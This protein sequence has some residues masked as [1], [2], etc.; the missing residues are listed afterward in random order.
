MDSKPPETSAGSAAPVPQPATRPPTPAWVKVFIVLGVL[1][2]VLIIVVL[3]GNLAGF[4]DHGP[5]RHFNNSDTSTTS[6]TNHTRPADHHAFVLTSS[7]P[8][9]I[10]T[11]SFRF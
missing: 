1:L 11:S 5:G 9:L 10:Q 6:E 7:R 3:V 4:G 2:L 8:G